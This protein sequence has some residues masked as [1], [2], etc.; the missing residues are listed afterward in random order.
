MAKLLC[1]LILTAGCAAAQMVEGNVFDASTG[2]GV[3]GV[4]V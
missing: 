4:K 1:L 3:G 2:D